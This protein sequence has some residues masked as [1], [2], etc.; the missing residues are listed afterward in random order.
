MRIG[1]RIIWLVAF[2]AMHIAAMAQP[3]TEQDLKKP[4]GLEERQLGSE[5]SANKKF[6]K[7][8]HFFQNLY[9]H[10]NYFYNANN[11]LNN[12]VERAKTQNRDDYTKM[13][14]FYN[15]SLDNTSKSSEIDSVINKSTAG[16]LLHDLRNDWIDNLY[17]LIG[18]AYLLRKNYDTA[19]MIFQYVNYAFAP[20]DKD[21]YKKI[22]GSNSTD[23]GSTLS[24]AT[25]DN[26][27][28]I[29][30]VF[31]RQPSRDESFIW[32]IRALTEMELYIDAA[33]LITTLKG[34]PIFPKR[35]ARELAED[36]AYNYYKQQQYDSSAKY[37]TNA[38]TLADNNTEKAR[39][40][41]LIGQMYQ[42]TSQPV[43]AA[44]YFTK[45]VNTTVDPIMEVYARL[46]ALRIKKN[47]DP[48]AIANN[49]AEMLK[50][51]KKERFYSSRDIIFYAAALSEMERNGYENA[52]KYLRK[53]IFYNEGDQTQR[54]KSFM[55]LGDI[56][57]VQKKYGKASLSYDSV[58]ERT[59][60]SLPALSL[61]ERKPGC[62][63][64]YEQDRIIFVQD[65]LQKI[66]LM[67][68][69]DRKLFVK[70]LSKKLRKAQGLKEE[71]ESLNNGL[72]ANPN[73]LGK[74]PADLFSSQSSAGSSYFDNPTMRSNGFTQFKLQWGN[75]ANVD[76]WRRSD[77]LKQL[78]VLA[79]QSA[80]NAA[81]TALSVRK[82][83]RSG[84]KLPLIKGE[85]NPDEPSFKPGDVSYEALMSN[86][87]LS[88]TKLKNSNSSI[89]KAMFLQGAALQNKLEDYP[90]AIKVYEALLERLKNEVPT[91]EV[92]FNL[93][94]CY[95][96]IGDLNKAAALRKRLN[97]EF[98]NGVF[99][100][101]MN[102]PIINPE[103][104][105]P[106]ATA[107]YKDIYN[108]FIEGDFARAEQEKLKADS[109]YKD[110]YWTPQLL[111]IEA[112]YYIKER[113]D[114]IA[115]QQLNSIINL[116]PKSLLT[117]KAKIMIDVL[118]RRKQI[119]DYLTKLDVKRANDDDSTVAPTVVP[120]KPKPVEEPPIARND[121]FN[122]KKPV[123]TNSI[124]KLKKDIAAGKPI[125][126]TQK[127]K[128][129][130]TLTSNYAPPPKPDT[131]VI[132][133]TAKISALPAKTD[134]SVKVAKK[135][136]PTKADTTKKVVKSTVPKTDTAIV[137]VKK[138]MP[139]VKNDS[140]KK[141]I[142]SPPIAVIPK[143]TG[144]KKTTLIN[145][146]FV[147]NPD[148]PQ[149]AVVVLNKVDIVYI[150]ECKNA[151][152]RYNQ[153]NI[154]SQH[155]ELQKVKL[156]ADYSLVT[157]NAPTF[158]KAAK[159]MEYVNNIKP[160][161]ATQ[162]VPWLNA[163]KFSIMMISQKNLDLLIKNMDVPAYLNLLKAAGY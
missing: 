130:S 57:F 151:F 79:Q 141:A 78:P 114:A 160:K 50:L 85:N 93:A 161:A 77:A 134:T 115:M 73:Q 23:G 19:S 44:Q 13:L 132:I 56:D 71:D 12:I 122:L 7:T 88:A 58:Q 138:P 139:I 34:D 104:K 148:E 2:T 3:N 67:P 30:K 113:K 150:N 38:V 45:C 43:L 125:V 18:R 99:T 40:Y 140:V 49:I 120:V 75:R 133:P 22:I 4:K 16:I 111:Y 74:G 35:L 96:K 90:E 60:D 87:P 27:S 80:T 28:I 76:D 65:S 70:T 135:P 36:E 10:Y 159:T 51:S 110:N 41:Y 131:A 116:F 105:D 117:P 11:I 154:H 20:T 6:T 64:I 59:L 47:D 72:A 162:I 68:E 91:E 142:V 42:A 158:T 127:I 149:M 66:A 62:H 84:L 103:K 108:M 21:G 83:S 101:R 124:T 109:I 119:E 53:S 82:F 95:S 5:K 52:E 106:A 26:K 14:S 15:Y 143:D 8:R 81:D 92:L 100:K 17:L 129:K 147:F 157:I 86:V 29:K 48:N 39:W 69:A 152:D 155:F 137:T 145:N 37:L 98:K 126:F 146:P 63:I 123:Y 46:A 97:D 144:A 112:V 25:K 32:Q 94:Y 156:N 107:K 128:G 33:S 55:L 153:V 54:S 61:K 121:S 89:N 31:E 136:T 102:T 163:D 9:T 1:T 118:S 24:I